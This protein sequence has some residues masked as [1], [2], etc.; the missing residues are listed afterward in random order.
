MAQLKALYSN[1][2]VQLMVH[3]F[4]KVF[5]KYYYQKKY[6]FLK[7]QFSPNVIVYKY[8]NTVL[9]VNISKQQQTWCH[10]YFSNCIKTNWMMHYWWWL[11]N[12]SK[13]F[14][15]FVAKLDME[16]KYFTTKIKTTVAGE[17]CLFNLHKRKM[18]EKWPKTKF[19]AIL[20]NF[21]TMWPTSKPFTPT[22]NYIQCLIF[23]RKSPENS[24]TKNIHFV[25]WKWIKCAQKSYNR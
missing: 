21:G 11:L 24:T 12:I 15:F 2:W 7:R 8:C 6:S 22:I 18:L 4:P 5:R 19:H 10:N 9:L 13:S 20:A 14:S 16:M 17:N 25:K 3:T 1:N 23:S